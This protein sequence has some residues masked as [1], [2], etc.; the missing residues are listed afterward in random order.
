MDIKCDNVTLTADSDQ[1]ITCVFTLVFGL[2]I[3][4][5]LIRDAHLVGVGV[6]SHVIAAVTGARPPTVDHVLDR[7]VG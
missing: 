7:Q 6:D 2:V 3:V 1:N 4:A 5:G